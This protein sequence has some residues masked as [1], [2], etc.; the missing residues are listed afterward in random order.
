MLGA[1]DIKVISVLGSIYGWKVSLKIFVLSLFYGAVWSVVKLII[2][3]NG[4]VRFCYFFQYL[5]QIMREKKCLPYR[6]GQETDKSYTI[7]FT[8]VILISYATLDFMGNLKVCS[9]L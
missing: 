8:V 9:F 3:R 6:T 2:Y 4:K 5:K 1:G 7:P